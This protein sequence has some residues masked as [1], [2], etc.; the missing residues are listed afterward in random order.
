[1][2]F[3][4]TSCIIL[5]VAVSCT[6]KKDYKYLGQTPPGFKAELFAPGIVSL[7]D[8]NESMITFSPDG[9]T[10][11]FTQHAKKWNS[12]S[13]LE[14]VLNDTIWTTP[15]KAS[16]SN[17]YSMCPSISS[18]NK[19][20]YLAMAKDSGMH[21]YEFSRNEDNSWSEPL[22]MNDEISSSS[23]EY[24][25]HPSS[26][27][28][29][30]VC[31]WRAGGVGGCD[32]WRIPSVNGKYQKAENLGLLNS[33][34]GDCVWAPGPD[35]KFLIFQSRRP[36]TGSIGGFF[37]TDLYIT[38]SLGDGQWSNPENLGPEVN[39][40]ATESSA[41]IT[42]DGKYLFFASNRRGSYDIYWVSLENILKNTP[43]EPLVAFN[44][45]PNELE[46]YQ[47]Y[48]DVKDN[49][50]TI[51]FNLE[52]D[53][54]VKLDILDRAGNKLATVLDEKRAT[55]QNSFIWEGQGFE[56]AEYLCQLIASDPSTG[57]I[58]RESTIQILLK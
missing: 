39:S 20:L 33:V 48:K 36:A 12:C 22:K 37:E 21:V 46:F 18:D 14:T 9:K 17:N 43:K 47:K 5:V 16:F 52:T 13:I 31:S 24:S 3:L 57:N 51:Y 32:G 6:Q 41:W 7:E 1:M 19:H 58:T 56:K 30:F 45:L 42:H 54:Q 26:L 4:I 53:C 2:K 25:C 29:M 49:T 27:G 10:C 38:F 50:T 11:Y 15:Q 28:S 34:V 55:G 40:S 8:R 23:A 35:E 44:H